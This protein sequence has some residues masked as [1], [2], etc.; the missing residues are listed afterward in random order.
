M[1]EY[2]GEMQYMEGV[3]ALNNNELK[4][5]QVDDEENALSGLAPYNSWLKDDAAIYSQ[6]CEAA[7]GVEDLVLDRFCKVYPN[8]TNNLICVESATDMIE[9]VSIYS[10]PGSLVLKVNSGFEVI[11]LENL[12]SG[13]YIIHIKL[14]NHSISKRLIKR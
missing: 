9:Q 8:P 1:T 3:N 7:L 14:A 2:E 6:D 12:Q 11:S 13:L 5:I 4:C 10:I